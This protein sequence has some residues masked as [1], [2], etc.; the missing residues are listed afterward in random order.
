MRTRTWH[1]RINVVAYAIGLGLF[2]LLLRFGFLQ[3]VEAGRY[4]TAAD[5]NS[6][7]LY[8]LAA[9]RGEIT[10]RHGDVLATSRPSF[11]ASLVPRQL[12]ED[13]TEREAAVAAYV[14]ALELDPDWLAGRLAESWETPITPI[15]LAGGLSTEMVARLEERRRQLPGLVIEEEPL[16]VYPYGNLAAHMLG[17]I[18]EVSLAELQE[19]GGRYVPGDLVGKFGVEVMAERFLKGDNG[20]LEVEVDAL[21]RQVTL[22]GRRP[23]RPGMRVVL[24]ID[25]RLQ[26]RAEELLGD[27]KGA[28]IAM[29]AQTGE[30]LAMAVNPRFDPNWFATGRITVARWQAVVNDPGTPLQ[31]R[32][33]QALYAPGSIFKIVTTSAALETGELNE[34]KTYECGGIFWIKTWSYKCWN[35]GGHGWLNVEQAIVHSCDIFFYKTGLSLTVDALAKYAELYGFGEPTGIDLPGEKGGHVPTRAWKERLFHLPWF[36][37]NTV[38]MAIG[39]SYLLCTPLQLVQLLDLVALEGRAVRPHVVRRV[40]DEGGRVV[41]EVTPQISRRLSIAPQ[42]WALLK[43]GLWGAVNYSS[44]TWFRAHLP[45]LSVSGKTSTIQNPHGENHAAFAGYAPSDK[46]EIVVATFIEHGLAGGTLAAL[47]T[48]SVISTWDDLRRGVEPESDVPVMPAGPA[49]GPPT[50]D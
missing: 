35:E 24:T 20:G 26:A 3:I 7:R 8:P 30:I 2:L 38:Q 49:A 45:R 6:I 25:R 22:R 1:L 14:R 12:P 4:R 17:Y 34:E 50:G 18:G 46:P 27:R 37:G 40:E 41:Q 42:T 29:E 28:V 31:N 48:R 36:P 16:R 39:Q 23:P 5:E 43:R 13:E 21:G 44:G 10:D 47:I 19:M 9:P 11:R 15:R 32:A 33:I